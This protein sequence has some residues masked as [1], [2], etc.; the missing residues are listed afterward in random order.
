MQYTVSFPYSVELEQIFPLPGMTAHLVR[1]SYGGAPV[2]L[3]IEVACDSVQSLTYLRT[4]AGHFEPQ[5][6][7]DDEIAR[8]R[9]AGSR[10]RSLVPQGELALLNQ[11]TE[12]FRQAMRASMDRARTDAAANDDAG[13]PG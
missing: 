13:I 12:G 4:V 7:W 5:G 10:S 3:R 6:G 11:A 2:P 8:A 9:H 1:R